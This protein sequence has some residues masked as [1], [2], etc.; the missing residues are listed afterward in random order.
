MVEVLVIGT[1]ILFL[2]LGIIVVM[3]EGSQSKHDLLM[4]LYVHVVSFVSLVVMLFGLGGLIFHFLLHNV[5]PGAAE[6]FDNYSYRIEQCEMTPAKIGTGEVMASDQESIEQCK[7]DQEALIIKERQADYEYN[8]LSSM[9]MLLVSLP[10]YAIHF[11][12]L[13]KK[14]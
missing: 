3:K 5:F 10:V 7:Q 1:A 12:Y 9:V 11:F 2:I 8:M 14:L 4:S 13:R 6:R